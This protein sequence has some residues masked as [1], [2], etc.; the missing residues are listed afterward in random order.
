MDDA[1]RQCLALELICSRGVPVEH[2]TPY[3]AVRAVAAYAIGK[4]DDAFFRDGERL[5]IE[6]LAAGVI[7]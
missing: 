7:A 3:G 2:L 4:T 1:E 6:A 5:F